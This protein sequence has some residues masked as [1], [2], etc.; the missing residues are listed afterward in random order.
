MAGH[1]LPQG[2]PPAVAGSFYP[3]DPVQCQELARRYT[4]VRTTAR[5]ET[6]DEW[7]GAWCDTASEHEALAREAEAAG[8]LVTAGEAWLRAAVCFHFAKFV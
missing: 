1:E 4:R 8:R 2:R 3:A 5:V 7:L 6:W